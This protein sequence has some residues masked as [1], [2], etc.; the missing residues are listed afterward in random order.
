MNSAGVVYILDADRA[1]AEAR[2][3]LFASVN[4]RSSVHHSPVEFLRSFAPDMPCCLVSAMR[5]P[6]LP[7]FELLAHLQKHPEPLPVIMIT[8]YGDVKTAV[9]AMKLGAAEF[10]EAPVHD[11]LLL[12]LVQHWINIDCAERGNFKKCVAV[13][14]KL[15]TLS[16]REHDV[17]AGLLDGL[18]NKEMARRL[19]VSPKSIEVYRGK[20]MA[21]MHANSIPGLVREVLC[22]PTFNCSP[23]SYCHSRAGVIRHRS[24][25]RLATLEIST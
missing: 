15:A 12:G 20:L 11:E 9:R 2:A 14:E 17:L 3:R 1:A 22:C 8:A 21:K 18:S 24:T 5:M 6:E 23:L 7:G 13:R 25:E 10:L 19:G 4:L 16:A